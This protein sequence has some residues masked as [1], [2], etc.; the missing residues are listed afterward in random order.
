MWGDREFLKVAIPRAVLDPGFGQVLRQV[1]PM[2]TARA[3]SARL[4]EI[5]GKPDAV[6]RGV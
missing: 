1:G 5:P 6:R 4:E 2:Q 3:I